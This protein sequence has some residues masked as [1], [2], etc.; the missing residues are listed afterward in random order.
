MMLLFKIWEYNNLKSAEH[1]KIMDSF[2]ICFAD[3]KL[4][5]GQ[6]EIG[7]TIIFAPIIKYLQKMG[8]PKRLSAIENKVKNNNRISI[9]EELT[10]I[11]V[12]LSVKDKFK[13][14]ME[15]RFVK[16]WK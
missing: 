3:S 4:C 2:I 7:Q 13:E 11:F 8:L 9:E 1:G 14:K 10:L 15:K 5:T 16:Y 12:A 6:I